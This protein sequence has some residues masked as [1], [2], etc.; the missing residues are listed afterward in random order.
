MNPVRSMMMMTMAM[1][2]LVGC[3]T[4]H[5][6]D[7][8]CVRSYTEPDLRVAGALTGPGVDAATGKLAAGTYLF[9]STYLRLSTDAAGQQTFQSAFKAISDSLA[10]TP[11][12]VAFQFATSDECLTARTLSVWK[13]DASMY[14][15]VGGA[16]HSSAISEMSKL[17]RGGGVVTHWSGTEADATMDVGI[18][19][20]SVAAGSL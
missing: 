12:L 2:A 13:D 10:T 17:S 8:L 5:P 18:A 4:A 14:G 15:F 3:G 19:H 20:V 1:L 6:N 11:G 9:S 16:A 7:T